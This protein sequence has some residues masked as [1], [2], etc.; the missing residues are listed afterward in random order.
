MTQMCTRTIHRDCF[1]GSLQ[2]SHIIPHCLF[3]AKAWPSMD[4]RLCSKVFLPSSNRSLKQRFTRITI[5]KGQRSIRVPY[6]I[7]KARFSKVYPPNAAKCRMQSQI[8]SAAFWKHQHLK[9]SCTD[10]SDVPCDSGD[11]MQW[12]DHK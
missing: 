1:K 9:L 12:M 2:Y 8:L 5:I 4:V 7:F 11:K 6:S 10:T 3:I